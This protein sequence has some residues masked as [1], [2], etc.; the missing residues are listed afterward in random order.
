M[1]ISVRKT[2]IAT[3]VAASGI[4]SS[5]SARADVL[6][7][8]TLVKVYTQSSADSDAHLIMV[9]TSLPSACN[10]NRMYIAAEDK[11][12]YAA[13][14]ANYLSGR[15][16]DIVWFPNSAPKTASG[17]LAGLTCRVVSIF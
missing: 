8:A 2:T 5:L 12:L 10:A 14:L 3:L 4:F 16:V 17:H 1:S 9:D 7:G 15:K 13:A 11:Q 6:Y